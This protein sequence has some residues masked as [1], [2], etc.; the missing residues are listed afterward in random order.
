MSDTD[1][2]STPNLSPGA[3]RMERSVRESRAREAAATLVEELRMLHFLSDVDTEESRAT[4]RLHDE[5]N[6]L[7][8]NLSTYL[9]GR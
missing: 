6:T 7:A 3:I 2:R 1:T 4:E 9:P 5:S 8:G